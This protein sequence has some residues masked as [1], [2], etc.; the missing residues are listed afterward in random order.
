MLLGGAVEM[1][2]AE[3]LEVSAA[4]AVGYEVG[5]A[6]DVPHEVPMSVAL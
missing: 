6:E 3:G 5:G 4:V 2:V 1:P